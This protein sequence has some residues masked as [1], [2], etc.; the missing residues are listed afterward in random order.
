VAIHS[1]TI[2]IDNLPYMA[3]ITGIQ[4]HQVYA[5]VTCNDR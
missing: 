4:Q 5:Q 1:I 2:L 3:K